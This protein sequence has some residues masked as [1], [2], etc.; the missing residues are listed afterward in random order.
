MAQIDELLTYLKENDASDLHL[1]AG[2][3]PRVRAKGRIQVI[4]GQPVLTDDSLRT[5]VGRLRHY[6]RQA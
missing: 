6:R 2:L 5:R 4:E 3:E 1:A